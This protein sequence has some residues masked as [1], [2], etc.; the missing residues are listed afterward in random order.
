MGCKMKRLL[1]IILLIFAIPVSAS[2]VKL[3]SYSDTCAVFSLSMNSNGSIGLAFGYYAELLGPD[4]KLLWKAPTRGIAYSS[5]LSENNILLI[6][7][8]GRWIQAFE[9]GKIIWEKELNNAVVSVS[10]SPNGD[11]AVAGDASG[12]VYF[13]KDGNLMWEKK[14]S[15]YVWAVVFQ[16]GKVFVGSNNGLSVFSTEGE[17][18]WDTNPG[19]VRKTSIADDVVVALVVPRSESWSELVAFDLNG[20]ILWRYRFPGYA[21]AVDTDG[22]N[23]AVAGNFGN[24]TLFS[25]DGK[26]LYSKPLIGYAYDV[27]TMKKYT[28]VGY[29]KTV[30]LIAPN[31]TVVWFERFNGTVYHVAFSP[32]GY[33]LTEHGSHDVQNCYGTI[34][35][36]ALTGTP[37]VTA[38]ESNRKTGVNPCITGGLIALVVLMGVLLWRKRS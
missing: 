15:D 22:E 3:W 26:L 18:I 30:E 8:E 29:G 1:T 19:P 2:P 10:I 31:G 17:L 32:K 35:A 4:G 6:G 5:A 28:V 14:I 24:V 21:R 20:K 36:W 34:D 38:Q 25:I 23:I 37:T 16:D 27:A 13:F 12:W 33:F 7:T 9:N 11:F